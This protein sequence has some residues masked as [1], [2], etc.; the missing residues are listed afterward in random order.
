M[1]ANEETPEQLAERMWN[2]NC[3]VTTDWSAL[4][5]SQTG[6]FVKSLQEAIAIGEDRQAEV[7]GEELFK[8][9][10]ERDAA[11]AAI[12]TLNAAKLN[13]PM[14]VERIAREAHNLNAGNG[15][16]CWD[17]LNETIRRFETAIAKDVIR[18][19]GLVPDPDALVV[20][21]KASAEMYRG[22]MNTSNEAQK[23][24][25]RSIYEGLKLPVEPTREER[26]AQAIGEIVSKW[27]GAVAQ[28]P[29]LENDQNG[30]GAVLERMVREGLEAGR[31]EKD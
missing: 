17:S 22:C 19:A 8:M 26:D 31:K 11:Q 14:N 4:L 10:Q 13:L 27:R 23:L 12:R 1:S 9:K 15:K 18:L 7:N 20:S 25:C 5:P 6:G 21:R 16:F 29:K 30:L 28:A 24:I 3:R 2:K